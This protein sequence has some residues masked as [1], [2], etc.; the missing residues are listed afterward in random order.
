[1]PCVEVN[2]VRLN[3][4][5][6]DN[7]QNG[8]GP[9]LVMIHGLAANLAFWYFEHALQ[10]SNTYRITLYDLRGHGRSGVTADGYTPHNMSVDLKMLLDHLG[11][12]RAHFVAHSFGGGVALNLAC[13]EPQRFNS[14]I[15]VDT[16]ITAVRR[17]LKDYKWAF[18]E[19]IK[20]ILKQHGLKLDID[21][22]YFGYKLLKLAAGLYKND[23]QKFEQE[24]EEVLRPAIGRFSKR[25]AAQ[26]L[27]LLESTNAE[28]ELMSDDGLTLDRLRDIRFPI[29]A[30]YGEHSQA[31]ST[32]RQLLK[33]WPHAEFYKMR[34]AGHFFPLTRAREFVERCRRFLDFRPAYVIRRRNGDV[35]K[36][37]FRSDRFYCNPDGA[38]FVDTRET[39][40]QGPFN[41]RDAAKSYLQ[42][43]LSVHS[44]MPR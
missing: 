36:S 25:T 30:M 7:C 11:V 43:T 40:R 18:G 15:L 34:G 26:W 37:F 1:M 16:H 14:L 17:C 44:L 38:W 23:R 28:H 12:T 35:Q 6:L 33:V 24:L 27:H 4:L 5:Q 21:E 22:P 29:L 8:P 2:G 42:T 41:S 13:Q 9:D 39:A 10:L 19:K 3:Y 32:G 20:P 31:M